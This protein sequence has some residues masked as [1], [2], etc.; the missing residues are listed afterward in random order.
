MS[1]GAGVARLSRS[2]RRFLLVGILLSIITVIAAGLT[3][4]D[5]RG[6][7]IESYRSNMK[8]LGVV[9]AEQTSRS[10]Q[11]VDLVVK[12]TG[13]KIL[14]AGV[15]T[16]EQFNRLM[17][18]EEIHD[19]LGSRLRSLPQATAVTLI[20]S[21]GNIVNSSRSQSPPAVNLSDRDYYTYLREH[22]VATSYISEPMK[23]RV[24]GAWSVYLARRVSGPHGEFLGLVISTLELQ[25]FE[26][27]YRTI[28]LQQ[29]G[30]VTLLRRDGTI[31]ARHPRTEDKI[32]R[33][34]PP[35]ALWY[36]CVEEGGG[37][38]RSPG[39]MDGDVRIVSVELL[40]DFPLV[41]DVTITED[42]AL[43]EWQRQSAFISIVAL[44]SIV[45]FAVL[46]RAL[47]AQ[48]RRIEQ[49]EAS[50]AAR[51][52][53][54]EDNRAR[55]EEQTAEIIQTAE[56]LH[57]SQ[58]MLRAIIDQIP[59]KI[60]A[61]DVD[62][63]YIVV[64]NMSARELGCSPE[65]AVGKRLTDFSIAGV[66]VTAET[67]F[68][69]EVE[70]RNREVLETGQ[71]IMNVEEKL[72]H[73]DGRVEYFLSSKA[74][75]FSMSNAVVG[76][77]T[78]A[79]D[80]T[81][82]KRAEVERR[83]LEQQ[84]QHAQKIEALGQLAGGV[85]HD[86]NNALVPILALTE[87]VLQDLPAGN[88]DR[89][90]LE[91]V[92]AGAKRARELV[93]QIL[94][95]SR[96]EQAARHEFDLADIAGEALLMLRA[97]VPS[98]IALADSI[99]P[100]LPMVGDPGQLHQVLVNLVM[101]AAQAIGDGQGTVTVQA[102]R[103]SDGSHIRVSVADTGCGMDE[104]TR[105]RVFEPFFTTKEVGKGTGLGLSIVHGIITNHGGTIDVESSPG[106]GTRFDILLP[107]S[108]VSNPSEHAPAEL[109]LAS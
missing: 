45:G 22:D 105:A 85:A 86:L 96:S 37:S 78:I 54:L 83:E 38:Y 20:G 42:E 1:I 6:A 66:D 93:R 57:D 79:I 70:N 72:A 32:G 62:L 71:P 33:R 17:A 56:A 87:L 43:A 63:R 5:L 7:A 40:H 90:P 13:A 104:A 69:S 74:P 91:L 50:L 101:N 4:W 27:F 51:N 75:M 39:Y 81:A 77:I 15:E 53:D 30:S 97:T 48:F 59:C 82:Q 23:S 9:L 106:H 99:E 60:S 98:T 52:I 10:M 35:E 44:C 21:D 109:S 55:L 3:I 84:L 92:L 64:N 76:V 49:S 16:P 73:D 88:H 89:G 65:E 100:A 11:A 94:A 108:P 107:T 67:E 28:T 95:F 46:F 61:K 80:I 41:V 25:Y 29:G 68:T 14:D 103:E 47:A 18:T 2:S 8:N 58:L 19:Y 36:P 12:E 102:L 26:A 34:M 24:T 31:L